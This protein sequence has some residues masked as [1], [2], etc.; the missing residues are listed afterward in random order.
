VHLKEVFV[1]AGDKVKTKQTLGTIQYD[2]QEQ[3][4]DLE[5]QIWKGQNKLDPQEWLF[6]K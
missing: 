2:E 4:S 3:V 6:K 5:L 1:K